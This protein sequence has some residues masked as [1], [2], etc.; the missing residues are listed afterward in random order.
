[1]TDTTTNEAG[2]DPAAAL[3]AT[4]D[5]HLAGYCEPDRARRAELLERAWDP[6]GEIADPPIEA[7]GR[8]GIVELV[9]VVLEHFPGHRFARTTAVDA[10]H[11]VARYGW[12]LVAPDGSTSVTGTDVAELGADGRL[13]RVVGF[14][15]ELAPA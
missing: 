15:G 1:M 4:I 13:T 12:A 2:T 7:Q 3:A 11:G 9:D 5:A 14:F 8:D 10:H 6:A